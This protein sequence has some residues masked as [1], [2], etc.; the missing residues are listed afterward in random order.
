MTVGA[1]QPAQA[2]FTMLYRASALA[3]RPGIVVLDADLAALDASFGSRA[4]IHALIAR[5]E[6]AGR[7]LPV[8]RGAYTMVDAG[9]TRE[10][11]SWIWLL[12]SRPSRTR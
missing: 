1:G 6:K 4:R 11:A 12:R 8:R 5:L 7:L 9:A 3:G 10:R 2:V